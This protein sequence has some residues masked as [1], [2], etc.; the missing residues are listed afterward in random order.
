MKSYIGGIRRDAKLVGEGTKFDIR[1]PVSTP[2]KAIIV[3]VEQCGDMHEPALSSLRSLTPRTQYEL[4]IIRAPGS[5]S[6]E[7][8]ATGED[9]TASVIATNSP[10]RSYGQCINEAIAAAPSDCNMIVVMEAGVAPTSPDWLERLAETALCSSVGVVAPVTLYPDHRIRHAGLAFE[11][12][13]SPGYLARFASFDESPTQPQVV[14]V[15]RLKRL[16]EVSAVSGHCMA[17]RRSVFADQGAFASD[18]AKD[19]ADVDFC[20]RLR[21]GGLSVLVDGRVVMVQDDPQPRWSR[22]IARDDLAM[23]LSRHGISPEVGDPFWRPARTPAARV[24]Q[25]PTQLPPLEAR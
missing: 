9:A 2:W 13:G 12:D 8:G 14:G 19:L 25:H 16:R 21:S 4:A 11:A 22:T 24:L 6:R 7:G 1:F 10:G 15:E 5:S 3:V 20:C 23:F 17:L 18:L